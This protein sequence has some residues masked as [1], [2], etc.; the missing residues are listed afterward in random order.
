M[1]ARYRLKDRERHNKTR[2]EDGRKEKRNLKMSKAY[3]DTIN[4]RLEELCEW[5]KTVCD[6][7]FAGLRT[8]NIRGLSHKQGTKTYRTTENEFIAL[9]F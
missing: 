9:K 4:A 3:S 1:C 8:R 2:R 6:R 5:W 7:E